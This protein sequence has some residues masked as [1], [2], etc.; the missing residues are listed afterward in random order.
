MSPEIPEESSHAYK[1]D[2]ARAAYNAYISD[3]RQ[4]RV[5][6]L[7]CVTVASFALVEFFVILFLLR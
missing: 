5:W 6:K 1:R 7:R 2:H 4:A 3:Y